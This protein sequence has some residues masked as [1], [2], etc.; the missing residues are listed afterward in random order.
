[1]VNFLLH[2]HGKV[3]TLHEITGIIAKKV[4]P[5]EGCKTKMPA[6]MPD[7]IEAQVWN[8]DAL[9]PGSILEKVPR[10]THMTILHKNKP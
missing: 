5:G 1:M 2:V 8:R 9:A 4:F 10:C 3:F 7:Y 6:H